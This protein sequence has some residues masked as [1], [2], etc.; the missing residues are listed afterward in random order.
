MHIKIPLL[1]LDIL[2]VLFCFSFSIFAFRIFLISEI[3]Q[4]SWNLMPRMSS[5]VRWTGNSEI[6]WE[7]LKDL[8]SV[9]S[10]AMCVPAMSYDHII[11]IFSLTIEYDHSKSNPSNYKATIMRTWHVILLSQMIVYFDYSSAS[12]ND[13]YAIWTNS[14]FRFT[15]VIIW[16]VTSQPLYVYFIWVLHIECNI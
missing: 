10:M 13:L 2:V 1:R 8:R 12:I 5:K 16:Y 11:H 14:V 9:F 7:N 6:V 4:D 15:L 3:E